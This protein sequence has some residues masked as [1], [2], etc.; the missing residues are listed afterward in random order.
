MLDAHFRDMT[1]NSRD[2]YRTVS[3]P[4]RD[5]QHPHHPV[6]PLAGTLNSYQELKRYKILFLL[7]TILVAYAQENGQR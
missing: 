3:L 1:N 7:R 6:E 4:P 2:L 5:Q